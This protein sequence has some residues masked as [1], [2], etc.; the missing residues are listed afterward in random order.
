[1]RGMSG[2]RSADI[3][4]TTASL[5]ATARKAQADSWPPLSPQ[6]LTRVRM[7]V[8][9]RAGRGN[10]QLQ[11]CAPEV[12]MERTKAI[13]PASNVVRFTADL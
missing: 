12:H 9:S 6:A 5:V 4:D 11:P 7:P 8:V 13:C 2:S 1:M 10:R 3:P